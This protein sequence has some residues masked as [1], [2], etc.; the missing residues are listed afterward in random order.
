MTG[1]NLIRVLKATLKGPQR[2]SQRPTSLRPHHRPR[3]YDVS[4][5]PARFSPQNGPPRAGRP[6]TS[7]AFPMCLRGRTPPPMTAG[8]WCASAMRPTGTGSSRSLHEWSSCAT[9]LS[10]HRQ[11]FRHSSASRCGCGP[12]ARS[13][14][15]NHS[16]FP[17]VSACVA[18]RPESNRR[19]HPYH[20]LVAATG[21]NPRQRF[22]LVSALF[23]P[24]HLPPL[25]TTGLHKGSIRAPS[26]V[27]SLDYGSRNR[28]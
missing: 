13:R 24:R 15:D 25:A 17:L 3:S 28:R 9:A 1:R 12:P 14:N 16:A 10:S 21:R 22:A 18:P 27:V 19:P 4:G 2:G 6:K 26:F 8:M 5:Q 7:L 11:A 23:G 20:A